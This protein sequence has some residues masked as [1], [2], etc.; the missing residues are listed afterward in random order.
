MP[1]EQTGSEALAELGVQPHG[2]GLDTQ[3]EPEPEQ[4]TEAEAETV[5]EEQEEKTPLILLDEAARAARG[6]DDGQAEYTRN[7]ERQVE[8]LTGQMEGILKIQDGK[9]A[10]EVPKKEVIGELLDVQNPAVVEALSEL[11]ANNPEKL[12]PAM[13]EI[14]G[15]QSKK[16]H[17]GLKKNFDN[18]MDELRQET[19]T[20]E[21]TTVLNKRINDNL[22]IA[23]N[24]GP[25]VKELVVEYQSTPDNQKGTTRMGRLIQN[26]PGALYS[27]TGLA[28]AL[29]G[30][31]ALAQDFAT[32][33]KGATTSGGATGITGKASLRNQEISSPQNIEEELDAEDRALN[34]LSTVGSIEDNLSDLFNPGVGF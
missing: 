32:A 17:S 26:N 19:K 10:G 15:E 14:M 20:N 29:R 1:E 30:I 25:T 31:E 27:E 23:K 8:R 13:L 28:L 24:Y 11:Q 22:E 2:E 4:K 12:I 34:E 3:T 33:Q 18:Q 21:S 16:I 7:L 9:I 6:G 5:T